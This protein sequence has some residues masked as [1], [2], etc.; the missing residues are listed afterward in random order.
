DPSGN[1][2]TGFTSPEYVQLFNA[3]SSEPDNDKRK[4]I[5]D[6]VNDLLLDQAFV[7]SISSAPARMVTKNYVKDIGRSLHGAFL[8]NSAWLDK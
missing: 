5:Y 2:N 1:S 6:Q 3:A 8:F 7:N 4:A